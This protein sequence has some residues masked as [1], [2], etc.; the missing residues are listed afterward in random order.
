NNNYNVEIAVPDSDLTF[1]FSDDPKW[2]P[3]AKSVSIK[4]KQV[5]SGGV[6]KR[7][8]KAKWGK[9]KFTISGK[10]S[11]AAG[12]SSIEKSSREPGHPDATIEIGTKFTGPVDFNALT[13][14]SYDAVITEAETIKA[15]GTRTGSLKQS[16]KSQS[17]VDA[18][19]PK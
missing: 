7:T 18:P 6:Q 14:V 9:G 5:M 19:L 2:Q 3:G 13:Y 8:I 15:D 12:M 11:L 10:M 1:Q 17:L 4:Q 16:R